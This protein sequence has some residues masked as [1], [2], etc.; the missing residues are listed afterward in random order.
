MVIC[1][2]GC[3]FE[4][5]REYSHVICPECKRIYPNLAPNMHHPLTEDELRWKCTACG[6]DNSNSYAGAP[7]RICE[8]CGA[9][10]P[11]DPAEW[12]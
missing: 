5:D 2:C 8:K 12:Y 4:N 10:R 6:A 3:K 9:K 7:R 1:R 11:G